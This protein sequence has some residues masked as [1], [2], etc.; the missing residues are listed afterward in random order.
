VQP[1][2]EPNPT[3]SGLKLIAALV[4]QIGGRVDQESSDQGTT[5]SL[6]FPVMS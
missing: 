1:L 4:R 6:M 3:D 5:T 2:T